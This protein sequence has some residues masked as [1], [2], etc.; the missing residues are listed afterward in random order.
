MVQYILRLRYST[1]T[2]HT[3]TAAASN[4]LIIR[5]ILNNEDICSTLSTT[6]VGYAERFIYKWEE[7]VYFNE[8]KASSICPPRGSAWIQDVALK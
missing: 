6:A 1:V 8:L 7:H 3:E 5:F 2:E 4:L